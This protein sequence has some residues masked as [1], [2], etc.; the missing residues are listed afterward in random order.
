MFAGW[1]NVGGS[2]MGTT[3][4]ILFVGVLAQ[5][6][7]AVLFITMVKVRLSVEGLQEVS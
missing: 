3:W 4:I 7:P 5:L 6:F 2:L 1:A